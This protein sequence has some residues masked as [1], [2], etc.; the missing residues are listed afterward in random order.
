MFP[1][2]NYN[3][4]LEKTMKTL[5]VNGAREGVSISVKV[6][7]DDNAPLI[8]CVH[9]WPELWYS[10]RHQMAYFAERGY[11][12]AAMDV[13]GYG[14]S[15]KPAAIEAYTLKQLA[16][17]VAAVAKALDP[18]PVI[19]FGHD[20]GAPIVH[21]TGLLYPELIRGIA[22]LSVPFTPWSENSLLAVMQSVYEGRFFYIS[23]FQQPST[24]EKEAEADVAVTL[25]KIY[26]SMSGN[27]PVGDW[28]KPKSLDDGLLD[29][30]VDP[31]PFPDWLS[32]R[33][34]EVYINAFESGGF[35]GPF[36]RYRALE[37]DNVDFS[38]YRDVHLS[39]PTCF[40]AGEV[41]AVRDYVPGVDGY[42][43][44]GVGCDDFRGSTLISG[45]G[46]WVQQEAPGG[47]NR[48][49]LH[50]LEGLK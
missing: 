20:W 30:L 17:D 31:E 44:P 8:L 21:N 26:Y 48:A 4:E 10:W 43:D 25:R 41:D 42:A 9:G 23:Y 13:R 15:S 34:L 22:G 19:L 29:H 50:F 38:E 40:I 24:P 5:V 27:S 45:V 47:T 32:A 11:R 33:D 18:N 14:G 1:K 28:L 35:T 12:V 6:E 16:G 39:M 2:V 3:H 49:L 46:H 7:G 37:M 36:N